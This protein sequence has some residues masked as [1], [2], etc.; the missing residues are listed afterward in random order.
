[1]CG[2]WVLPPRREDS[3]TQ[4]FGVLLRSALERAADREAFG[5]FDLVAED[6]V[7]HALVIPAPGH[8][9]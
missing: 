3:G 1:M 6:V 5:P 9:T 7:A 4:A 8:D 2:K